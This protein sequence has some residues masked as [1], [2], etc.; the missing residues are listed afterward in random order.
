MFTKN[1]EKTSQGISAAG[2][3]Q[4]KEPYNLELDTESKAKDACGNTL[5]AAN[6]ATMR[7]LADNRSVRSKMASRLAWATTTT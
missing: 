5:D 7:I 4:P 3:Y 6:Q 2:F 1:Q